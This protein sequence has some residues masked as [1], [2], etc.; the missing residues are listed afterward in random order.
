[1][2]I[3]FDRQKHC[4]VGLTPEKMKHLRD[5]Y[6]GVD[7][8]T[9]LKKMALWLSSPRGIRKTGTINFIMNW[10]GNCSIPTTNSLKDDTPSM[11]L[12]TPLRPHLNEYLK[13]LWKNREHILTFNQKT[14]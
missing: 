12:D 2:S 3:Y 1:M 14:N 11:E 8:E 4:F 5:A 9:E 6:R 10:L 7:I 13:G